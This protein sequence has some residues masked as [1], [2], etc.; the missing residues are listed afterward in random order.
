MNFNLG[1]RWPCDLPPKPA[2]KARAVYVYAI[3]SIGLQKRAPAV[4]IICA[5]HPFK[6]ATST[7]IRNIHCCE[8]TFVLLNTVPICS[9]VQACREC[10]WQHQH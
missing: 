8:V 6:S 7:H 1:G 5:A 2:D 9:A 4:V 3:E 10:R